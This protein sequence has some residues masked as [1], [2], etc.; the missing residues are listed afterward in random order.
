MSKKMKP[1]ALRM[2]V[3][4]N[5]ELVLN[6]HE[7]DELRKQ[8]RAMVAG[9]VDAVIRG[10]IRSMIIEVIAGEGQR[11]KLATRIE[12]MT[13]QT[14]ANHVNSC[15]NESAYGSDHKKLE[16]MIRVMVVEMLK[17][18]EDYARTQI[19][20]KVTE[21]TSDELSRIT[22]ERTS[23]EVKSVIGKLLSK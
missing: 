5:A 6:I 12:E 17:G 8:V 22:A 20:K 14:I 13:K 15:V 21:L 9:Q 11:L 19:D 23:E 2:S 18:Q 3:L 10:E 1:V 16:K 7:D 4:E